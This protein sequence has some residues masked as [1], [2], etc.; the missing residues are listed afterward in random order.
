MLDDGAVETEP[1]SNAAS[2]ARALGWTGIALPFLVDGAAVLRANETWLIHR[3]PDDAFYYFEIA[4]RIGRGEGYT[5]DGINETNGFHPLWQTMLVPVGWLFPSDGAFLRAAVLLSLVASLVAILLVVRI[6]WRCWGSG[7][8]LL[9][10]VAAANFAVLWDGM[11]GPGVILALALLLTVLVSFA[12]RPGPGR[13]ALCG[14]TAALCILARFDLMAVVWVIPLVVALRARSVRLGAWSVAGAACIGLPFGAYW[15]SRWGSVLTTSATVK[16]ASLGRTIDRR[17][18]G[19]ATGGY[20]GFVVDTVTGYIQSVLSRVGRSDR[21]E[22]SPLLALVSGL[23]VGVAAMGV[24]V[25]FSAWRARLSNREPLGP[26]GWG[27]L[28]LA[29]ILV[30]K[31]LIDVVVAPLWAAAWYSAPQVLAVSFVSGSLVW[32]AAV[33]VRDRSRPAS[34]GIIA[35]VA[36]AVVLNL[37]PSLET[38]QEPRFAA[39]WQDQMDLAAE[40][41]VLHGPPGRYGGNDTGLLGFRLDG[42]HELVNLDGLVNDYEYAAF[43]SGEPNMVQKAQRKGVDLLIGRFPDEILEGP[44]TCGEILWESPGSVPYVDGLRD[45]TEARVFVVDV[46]GCS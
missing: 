6:V 37:R 18:G 3:L 40:W 33:W 14:A 13:A 22:E 38:P 11:E 15:L 28:V 42:T 2:F 23:L 9:G 20:A 1:R 7:P 32:N 25:S 17:F 34:V 19:R 10:G 30:A 31:A 44:L 24:V 4:R 39:S 27:L 46:R 29:G 41:V 35:L 12:T 21:A 16:E 45:L 5:F 8:A 26:T 43:L 36:V